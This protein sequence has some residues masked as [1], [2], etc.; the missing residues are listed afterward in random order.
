MLT[1]PHRE[2]ATEPVLTP[3]EGVIVQYSHGEGVGSAVVG[4]RRLR[5]RGANASGD[6][7]FRIGERVLC[8]VLKSG[9][10]QR[11]ERLP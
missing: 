8:W 5:F 3:E 11:L 9:F 1:K 6:I 10:I 4:N 2:Q 7:A